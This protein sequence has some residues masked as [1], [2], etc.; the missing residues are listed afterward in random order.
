MKQS[1][2]QQTEEIMRELAQNINSTLNQFMSDAGFLLVVFNFN[3]PGVSNYVS[4]GNR[5]SM[6]ETLRETANRL[7][8]GE[9]IPVSPYTMQ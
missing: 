4:N 8:K 3:K 7:E 6:I 1:N 2:Q 5:E 9:N